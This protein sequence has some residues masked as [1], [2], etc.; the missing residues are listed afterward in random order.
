[1]MGERLVR[2]DTLF[3]EFSLEGQ[4]PATHLLR[5]IDGFVELDGLRRDLAPFYRAVIPPSTKS[6]APVT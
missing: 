2:Q 3:Y 4:V 5:S 6:R 1:M